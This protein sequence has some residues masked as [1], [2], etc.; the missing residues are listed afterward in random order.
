M[1]LLPNYWQK[2][3]LSVHVFPRAFAR[4]RPHLTL[5]QEVVSLRSS[6]KSFL[7]N[8]PLGVLGK[9]LPEAAFSQRWASGDT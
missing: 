6:N 2:G 9:R 1:K 3:G 7:W 5:I 8:A 4:P